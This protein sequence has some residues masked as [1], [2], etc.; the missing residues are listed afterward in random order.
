M[1]ENLFDVRN[2][3]TNT[4][5]ITNYFFKDLMCNVKLYTPKWTINETFECDDLIRYYYSRTQSNDN[6]WPKDKSTIE[7]IYTAIRIGGAGVAMKPSNFP[8]RTIDEI[9]KKYNINNNYYDFS[10][11][12]GVR[13]L[14]ALKNSVNYHGTDP[15]HVLV[16]RLRELHR[17]YADISIFEANADIRC[18]GSEVFH[19]DWENKMGLAFSSPP[20][21]LILIPVVVFPI[22]SI[23]LFTA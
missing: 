12:W 23:P 20:Y 5:A 18:T 3:G 21:L 1:V 10:C 16:D 2:G 17:E 14:S 11:G 6:L 19:A 8:M 9:L 22:P 7:N 15:N 13:M 4:T